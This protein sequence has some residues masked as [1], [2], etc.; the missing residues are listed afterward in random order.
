M[1][2]DSNNQELKKPVRRLCSEIQLF[3]LCDLDRCNTR[4]GRFCTKSEL[5]SRFEYISDREEIPKDHYL[6]N[7]FDED[8]EADSG[9]DF[10]GTHGFSED[11]GDRWEDE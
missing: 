8:E 4:D 10:L 1:E 11:T 2:V 5:L 6:K 7:E 9:E 3:D